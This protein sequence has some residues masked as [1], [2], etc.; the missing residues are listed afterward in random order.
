MVLAV[1]GLRIVGLGDIVQIVLGGAIYALLVL[2]TGAVTL[3]DLRMIRSVVVQKI[4]PGEPFTPVVS[5][6]GRNE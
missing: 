1:L 6:G 5:D 3:N 4:R 2:V